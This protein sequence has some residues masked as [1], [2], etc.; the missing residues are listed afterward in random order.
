LILQIKFEIFNPAIK[1][2]KKL[3][4]MYSF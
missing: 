4:S 2:Y 3:N 1:I